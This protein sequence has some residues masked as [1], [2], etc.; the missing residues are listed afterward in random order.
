VNR[1]AVICL[2]AILAAAGC[3]KRPSGPDANFQQASRLYQQ[4]Y[5]TELDDAYGDARIETVI[6]QLTKV[7]PNSVDAEAATA[8]LGTIQRGK[9]ALAQDRARREKISTAAQ[10]TAAL[11]APN[12]DVQKIISAGTP[13]AGPPPDPYGAGASVA[14]INRATG[15]CLVDG[16]PF[17]EQGTSV[18]G[19]VYRVAS[20]S[21]CSS[22]LPG[23]VGQ[24]VLV[25]NGR[26]YRRIA[27][28]NPPGA[29]PPPVP[30]AGA[31][32]AAAKPKPAAQPSAGSD[33]AGEPQ[34]YYPGQPLPGAKPPEQP[35]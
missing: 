24:A 9:E 14:E 5:A 11:P 19:T 16:E 2:L 13:D 28:P 32:A 20:S 31:P 8:L 35:Q 22:K 10:I 29:A 25:V 17:N 7:D 4:L 21:D 23:Y 26:I 33:D 6:M 3:R 1:R 18:N 12:I 34:F 27:D 30:D 15:G